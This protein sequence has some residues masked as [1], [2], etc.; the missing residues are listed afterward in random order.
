M[1]TRRRFI[2]ILAGCSAVSPLCGI[3]EA[4]AAAAPTVSV[5]K[6]VAMG[7]QASLTLVHPQRALAQALIGQC[8]HEIERLEAIFSLYRPASALSRLNARG[9]LNDPPGELVELL[10]FGLALARHSDG[11]FDPTVQPLWRL[12]AD[13]FAAPGARAAG[14]APHEIARALR[15]VGYRQLEVDAGRIRL[16]RPGMA[17]TLNGIAQG[18]VTDR[19]T[20]LLRAAGF[21]DVLVDLGEVRVRG[22]RPTGGMWQAAIADPRDGQR[23]LFELPLGDSAGALPALATPAGAGTPLGPDPRIHHLFDPH[24]GRSANHYLSVSAAAPRATL[25]D[26]LST[27]LAVLAPSRAAALLEAYPAVRAYLVDADG[28]LQVRGSGRPQG[29]AERGATRGA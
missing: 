24:T 10:S 15:R 29:F 28:R 20:E 5:W 21:D 18:Y 23:T 25:A 4:L 3:G 14:P 27:T 6:G 11:A 13:H 8:T 1:P 22:Q 12:Y 26:G 16:R 19:V 2:S 7:A 9:E 17:V